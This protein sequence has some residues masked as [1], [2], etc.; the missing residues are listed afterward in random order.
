[1]ELRS[2]SII[3]FPKTGV[4]APNQGLLRR[5]QSYWSIMLVQNALALEVPLLGIC[6]FKCSLYQVNAR[7]RTKPKLLQ[8]RVVL[9]LTTTL[10]F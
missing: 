8:G 10:L 5:Q 1:M 2:N 7:K 6:S 9:N 3:D 4:K